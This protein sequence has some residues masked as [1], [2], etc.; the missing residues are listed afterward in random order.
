MGQK[1]RDY[2][3]PG[4]VQ[5]TLNRLALDRG[6]TRE[7]LEGEIERFSSEPIDA[8]HLAYLE[9]LNVGTL[10]PDREEHL[11]A[12]ERCRTLVDAFHP[13][14]DVARAFREAAR[15]QLADS[16]ADEAAPA[17]EIARAGGY[18]VPATIAVC[19][20]VGMAGALYLTRSDRPRLPLSALIAPDEAPLM[21]R[22]LRPPLPS[23]LIPARGDLA[24]RVL[25]SDSEELRIEGAETWGQ[26]GLRAVYLLTELSRNDPSRR[27]RERAAAALAMVNAVGE[28]TDAPSSEAPKPSQSEAKDRH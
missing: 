2:V 8:E 1:E 15:G 5:K 17:R 20:V 12:C 21:E 16:Y 9:T 26:E 28:A 13:T 27:V 18:L 25:T 14:E 3:S 6:L 22:T 4:A 24:Q 7:E 11:R 23:V 19:M 10:P